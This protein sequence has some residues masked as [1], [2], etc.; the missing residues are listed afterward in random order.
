MNRLTQVK[1]FLKRVPPHYWAWSFAFAL[2]G[3]GWGHA[4]LL[5]PPPTYTGKVDPAS[6]ASMALST[7]LGAIIAIVGI[8]L[9]VALSQSLRLTGLWIELIGTILLMGGPLQFGLLQVGFLYSGE[10][11]ARYALAWFAASMT[12][13][14]IVRYAYVIPPLAKGMKRLLASRGNK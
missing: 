14:V 3:F 5:F 13:F 12:A 9:T 4:I 8:F 11:D 6:I 2:L 7:G 1:D 10:F